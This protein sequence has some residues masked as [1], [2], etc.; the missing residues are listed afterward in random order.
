MALK[1]KTVLLINTIKF[2]DAF[3]Q[4][5]LIAMYRNSILQ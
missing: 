4:H 3:M 5:L 1:L 2:K